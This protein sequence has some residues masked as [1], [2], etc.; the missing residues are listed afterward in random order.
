MQFRADNRSGN[1][2]S[3]LGFGCMRFPKSRGAIDLG[4]TEWLIMEA[5]QGGVNY[6]D[7]AYIYGGSEE[8]LGAVL[9]KNKVRDRVY[10]AS[11][12]PLVLLR[13]AGDFDKFFNKTLE[14]LR[15]DHIDYYLMHMLTDRRLWDKLRSWGI[16]EWIAAQQKSGR[17]KQAGFSFH[18]SQNEFLELLDVYD[19]DFCQIQYNYTQENYQAGKAGLLKAA[20]K[21]LPVIIMEPLLGG[22]L[23]TGLPREAER[24]FRE[25]GE[26]SS[27]ERSSLAERSS[28][29]RRSPAEWALRWVW[30]HPE[31]TVLLSGMNATAQ[32]E[33]NLLLADQALPGSLDAGERET[34]RRVLEVFN[35]S[36]KVPC[37]GCNYCMPCPQNVN[38]PGCFAAYN[39]SYALGWVQGMQQYATSTGLTSLKTGRPGNCVKC[40]ACETHC[41]QHIPIIKTL[42]QV[43]SRMEPLPVRGGI[44]IFRAFMGRSRPFSS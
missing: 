32:L 7:T 5:I 20:G 29:E 2:L 3:A 21:G 33:E 37:T 4:K 26:R 42:G 25:A 34:Y 23:A 13:E 16:E 17:I 44:G 11:K 19:W 31:A 1:R 12:L 41:P 22:R 35:A 18:G 8:A 27:H 43:R 14:R 30:D 6:F 10:I 40:G 28:E 38:I 24:I 15:T 39:T 9:E 36:Y